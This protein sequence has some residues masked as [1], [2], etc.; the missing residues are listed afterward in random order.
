MQIS[1][2]KR[3]KHEKSN[4]KS[5]TKNNSFLSEVTTLLLCL[6]QQGHSFFPLLYLKIIFIEN[7]HHCS[8]RQAIKMV[9]LLRTHI[10]TS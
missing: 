10:S 3:T 2:Q 7:L 4:T 9:S 5:S 6:L 8:I 1:T